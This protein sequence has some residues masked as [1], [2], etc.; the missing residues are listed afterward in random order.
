VSVFQ[1]GFSFQE[2]TETTSSLPVTLDILSNE[3]ASS[4]SAQKQ[5][6]PVRL[7]AAGSLA[8]LELPLSKKILGHDHQEGDEGLIR[9]KNGESSYTDF[10]AKRVKKLWRVRRILNSYDLRSCTLV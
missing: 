3:S 8:T 4:S 6:D 7:T 1:K 9:V 10:V 2:M 5:Y